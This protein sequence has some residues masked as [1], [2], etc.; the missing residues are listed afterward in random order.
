H[1]SGGW[2]GEEKEG[3]FP[4]TQ[5]A[6]YEVKVAVRESHYQVFVNG[7]Y[8][9][10]FNHRLEKGIVRNVFVEGDSEV[11]NV[12][13]VDKRPVYSPQ[14]PFSIP[15]KG[16]VVPG[17]KILIAGQPN[18]NPERFNVNLLWGPDFDSSDLAL[19]FDARINY[20]DNQ[21]VSV[22]THRSGGDY[23]EEERGEQFFPFVPGA[24]FIMRIS[25]E[26]SGFVVHVNEQYHSTFAHRIQPVQNITHLA[27]NGDVQVSQVRFE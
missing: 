2:G 5:G 26:E 19:H 8:F 18:S 10:Q 27:V 3:G 15:I 23:G 14:V 9:C 4:F 11:S 22:R 1:F 12:L 16:G 13:F 6:P 17:T 21:N 24:G 25:V 7:F 20:G